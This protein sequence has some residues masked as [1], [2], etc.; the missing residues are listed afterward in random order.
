MYILDF[1]YHNLV[2]PIWQ[3]A[4]PMYWHKWRASRVLLTWTSLSNLA[5]SSSLNLWIPKIPNIQMKTTANWILDKYEMPNVTATISDKLSE[6]QSLSWKRIP[7]YHHVNEIR[8]YTAPSSSLRNCYDYDTLFLL[9]R[10]GS[11]AIMNIT[12]RNKRRIVCTQKLSTE[13]IK[14]TLKHK[15]FMPRL[16]D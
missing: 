3:I 11:I 5:I 9:D 1:G 13:L 12:K 16:S 10:I 7:G 8:N 4:M 15:L 6:T 2:K 14:L